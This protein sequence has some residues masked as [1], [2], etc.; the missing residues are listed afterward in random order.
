ML[1]WSRTAPSVSTEPAEPSKRPIG[2]AT[3]QNVAPAGTAVTA[4]APAVAP[5]A[6]NPRRSVTGNSGYR[7]DRPSSRH[8]Q[9]APLDI[10]FAG[11]P[12]EDLFR[13]CR[14]DAIDRLSKE[15]GIFQKE[16][17]PQA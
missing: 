6:A 12:N 16:G 2:P 5:P 9:D 11:V 13:V 17:L 1:H 10:R 8:R 3:L 15:I 14:A 7:R 4:P